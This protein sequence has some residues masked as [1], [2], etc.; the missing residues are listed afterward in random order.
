MKWGLIYMKLENLK[1]YPLS[2]WLKIWALILM[3][4]VLIFSFI[5][6]IVTLSEEEK[7]SS[8]QSLEMTVKKENMDSISPAEGQVQDSSAIE[9]VASDNNVELGEAEGTI[10]NSDVN[11]ADSSATDIYVETS[12]NEGGSS[13]EDVLNSMTLEEKIYQMFIV[14]PETL[15]DHAVGC[16][17]S[18]GDT[19]KAALV[20]KPVGGIIYFAQNLESRD[21]TRSMIENAQIYAKE[22]HGVGLWIA[23]D[24]EGGN[25]ARVASKLG[26]TSY[27]SMQYYGTRGDIDEISNVGVGIANDISQFGFNLDFAPVADVNLNSGNELGSRIFSSDVQVVSEMVGAMV[28]GLQSSGDVSATLKHFPGLGAE[29]GN[30]HYDTRAIID[31]TYEELRQ[32]EFTA[33]QGGIDAGADFVMVGHQTMPAAGDNLP[34]DLS[35]V[36][37]TDWLRG[38]LGFQGIVVT[39]SQQMNTITNNYNSADAAVMSIQAG[40]DI[41]LMPSNL[42]SAYQGVYQAVQDGRISEERINESVRRILTEKAAHGLL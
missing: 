5:L 13:V 26:T 29:S 37:V 9:A 31:R 32:D 15:V 41:V 35:E 34:S 10:E 20:E 1:R 33:F 42:T 30:T 28:R 14:D 24:E 23:V 17:V 36:V 18:S 6:A 25:V 3:I 27:E 12:E 16:V 39:D 4:L 19:T 38:E 8:S 22:S 2:F 21:Q 40:V 11:T 7:V